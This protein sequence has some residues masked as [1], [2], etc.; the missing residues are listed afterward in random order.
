MNIRYIWNRIN[1]TKRAMLNEGAREEPCPHCGRLTPIY[2]HPGYKA[3]AGCLWCGKDICVYVC[4]LC[5]KSYAEGEIH[6][7][8]YSRGIYGGAHKA[9]LEALRSQGKGG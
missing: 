9:C 4:Q 6:C 8:D 7:A 3:A 5:G 1:G 2:Y